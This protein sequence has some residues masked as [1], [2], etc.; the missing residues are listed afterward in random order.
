MMSDA[1]VLEDGGLVNACNNELDARRWHQIQVNKHQSS[2][3][4]G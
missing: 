1:L 4:K 3:R 2:C